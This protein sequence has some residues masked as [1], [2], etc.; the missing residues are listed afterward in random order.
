MTNQ[1]PTEITQFLDRLHAAGQRIVPG[2]STS[3]R[4]YSLIWIPH[5]SKPGRMVAAVVV[6]TAPAVGAKERMR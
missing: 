5:P 4:M 3:L 1:P 6:E 2:P